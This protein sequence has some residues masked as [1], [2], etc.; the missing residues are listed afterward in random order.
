MHYRVPG[1]AARG[2]WDKL[3]SVLC[4]H[5]LLMTRD[6]SWPRFGPQFPC[7]DNEGLD[8]VLYNLPL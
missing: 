1:V 8:M 2:L 4:L 3:S 5:Q 6:K 7:L